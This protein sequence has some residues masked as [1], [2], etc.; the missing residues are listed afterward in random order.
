MRLLTRLDF[1]GLA[2]ATLLKEVTEIDTVEF[3]HPKDMQ[4]GKIHVTKND[5]I[6][7]LPYHPD[8]GVW[9]DHHS[10]EAAR[11]G[12]TSFTGRYEIAPSTARVVYNH[13]T[14][15]GEGEK[16]CKYEPLVIEVDKVDSAM[17]SPEDVS[18]PKGW[19]LLA[20]IMDPRSGLTKGT[21]YQIS[22]YE[23]MLKMI[24][25]MR[26]HSAEEILE[27]PDIKERVQRYFAEEKIFKEAL[28]RHSRQDEN[29]VI[30]DFR[31]LDAPAGNRFLIYTLFPETN[32]SVRL[33]DGKSKEITVVACGHSIFN[34]TSKTDVGALMARYGGGGHKGAGTC[35]IGSAE[36]DA[37]IAEITLQMKKDG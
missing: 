27:F 4:D 31:G 15:K 5:I 9:F 20:Y 18:C 16:L 35:Q 21:T 11:H 32:I 8:S 14:L 10:S 28:L 33:I 2:C 34:R 30:T 1:D 3:C 24:N 37:V 25:W 12:A 17:L 29:V 26:E 19:V 6:T 13:F 36:A 7:N 23:L 22:N